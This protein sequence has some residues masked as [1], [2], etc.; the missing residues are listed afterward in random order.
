MAIHVACDARTIVG[1]GPRASSQ[2]THCDRMSGE[3]PPN[4]MNLSKLEPVKVKLNLDQLTTGH[5]RSVVVSQS[6]K[7]LRRMGDYNGESYVACD[8]HLFRR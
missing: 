2:F 3:R 7:G 8:D 6:G 1:P 4:P 5:A